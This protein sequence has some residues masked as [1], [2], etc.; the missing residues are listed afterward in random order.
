MPAKVPSNSMQPLTSIYSAQI[1]AQL[2]RFGGFGK[3]YGR[4]QRWRGYLAG[5][6]CGVATR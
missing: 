5:G 6:I 2:I 4:A 1:D 3:P